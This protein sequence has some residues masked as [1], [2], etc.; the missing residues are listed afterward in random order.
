MIR[1][2][3]K[4]MPQLSNTF[5][6]VKVR[7]VLNQNGNVEDVQVILPSNVAGL[8]QSVAF[9]VKQTSFPFPAP[10][11]LPVDRIFQVTYIYH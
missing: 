10:N 3:K 1:A 5:G 7:I 11:S 2:L 9:A 6:S 4:T 8:D